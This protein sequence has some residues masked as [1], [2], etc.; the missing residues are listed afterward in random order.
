MMSSDRSKLLQLEQLGP[1]L[2]CD[3]EM[4]AAVDCVLPLSCW[5]HESFSG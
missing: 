2:Y 3:N 5:V 4:V 1:Q